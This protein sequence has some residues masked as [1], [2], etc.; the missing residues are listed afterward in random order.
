MSQNHFLQCTLSLC[1][2]LLHCSCQP[3]TD[4]WF[5]DGTK[6]TQDEWTKDSYVYWDYS[7]YDG[8]DTCITDKCMLLW[9]E[10]GTDSSVSRTTTITPYDQLRLKYDLVTYQLES[11]DACNIYYAYDSSTKQLATSITPPSSAAHQYTDQYF[12]FSSST[13]RNQ[14]HLWLET[15]NTDSDKTDLC[16]WDNIYLQGAVVTVTPDPS[17]APTRSPSHNPSGSPTLKPT[18]A[19]NKVSTSTSTRS[20]SHNPSGSPTLKPTNAPN[21]VSTSTSTR[22]PS[23]NP[24]G[25]P[26]LKPTNAPNKVSTSTSIAPTQAPTVPASGTSIIYILTSHAPTVITLSPSDAPTDS[27][28][29]AP[30]SA[31]TITW[32]LCTPNLE[33]TFIGQVIFTIDWSASDEFGEYLGDVVWVQRRLEH[34]ID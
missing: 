14:I 9:A 4:I 30:T 24:S 3:W 5:E 27:P 10:S 21:K 25:S 13:N 23:H 7:D 8:Q 31:P 26:T 11:N 2:C 12:T 34:V 29:L 22:S 18:N 32:S 6:A 19:P 16:F 1:L 15:S 33:C 28:S 17:S 20:P